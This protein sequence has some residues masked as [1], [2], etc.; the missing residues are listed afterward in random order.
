MEE[1]S[2]KKGDQSAI[3]PAH[4]TAAKRE[5]LHSRILSDPTSREYLQWK[6]KTLRQARAELEAV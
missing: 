1:D 6:E 2:A 4:S 5:T 3:E